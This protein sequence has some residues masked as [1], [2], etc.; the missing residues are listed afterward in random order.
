MPLDWAACIPCYRAPLQF[1][2][3]APY[4][5]THGLTAVIYLYFGDCPLVDDRAELSVVSHVCQKKTKNK[6]KNLQ[7]TRQFVFIPNNIIAYTLCGTMPTLKQGVVYAR[8]RLI[9]RC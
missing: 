2:A 3:H 6:N 1:A 9:T 8:T 4:V 7:S 5:R